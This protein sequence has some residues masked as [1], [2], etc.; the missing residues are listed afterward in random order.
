[1]SPVLRSQIIS[2]SLVPSKHHQHKPFPQTFSVFNPWEG[3][4][5]SNVICFSPKSQSRHWELRAGM[6]WGRSG[7]F[8]R[9]EQR[10]FR[11][12]STRGSIIPHHRD[13]K[14]P[15]ALPRSSR[16]REAGF[17]QL[18]QDHSD[19]PW[20]RAWTTLPFL[21][22]FPWKQ[23]LSLKQNWNTKK[24]LELRNH[25]FSFCTVSGFFIFF[26]FFFTDEPYCSSCSFSALSNF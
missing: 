11:A 18:A 26:F 8:Q 5:K 24:S 7:L 13:T 21:W 14:P 12:R 20:L 2:R 19:R 4:G 6:P 23:W 9:P 10:H 22:M 15:P 3:L 16:S 1:M 17:G 25:L